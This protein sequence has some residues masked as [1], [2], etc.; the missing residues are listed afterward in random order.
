LAR[1]GWGRN[2]GR[3]VAALASCSDCDLL[4]RKRRPG[5]F[6]GPGWMPRAPS[7]A[8]YRLFKI[9][10]NCRFRDYGRVSMRVASAR[11]SYRLLIRT[12]LVSRPGPA[13]GPREAPSRARAR[14]R[15]RTPHSRL[16]LAPNAPR[17]AR[18]CIYNC[19]VAISLSFLLFFFLSFF[20]SSHRCPVTGFDLQPQTARSPMAGRGPEYG[21]IILKSLCSALGEA[22]PTASHPQADTPGNHLVPGT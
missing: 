11:R 6:M 7:A 13:A 8:G 21:R 5:P 2:S 16:C 18:I 12:R 9:N 15:S 1:R 20:L 19:A 10:D 14:A 17:V 3:L 4:P 22:L